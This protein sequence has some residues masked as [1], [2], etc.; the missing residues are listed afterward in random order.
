MRPETLLVNN[1]LDNIYCCTTVHSN[2][3]T[4]VKKNVLGVRGIK[5]TKEEKK[6]SFELF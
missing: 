2:H 6:F 1:K 4:R 5:G 3:L